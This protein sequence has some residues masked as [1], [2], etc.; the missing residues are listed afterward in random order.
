MNIQLL[1]EAKTDLP[2]NDAV[3]DCRSSP[4]EKTKKLK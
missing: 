4:S 1:E 3:L 2:E